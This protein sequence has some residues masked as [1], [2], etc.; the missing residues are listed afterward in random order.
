MDWTF[1]YL[2]KESAERYGAVIGKGWGFFFLEMRIIFASFLWKDAV[3]IYKVNLSLYFQDKSY[4]QIY[5]TPNDLKNWQN[6]A[7][8]PFS[9]DL[10]VYRCCAFLHTL[11]HVLFCP[12]YCHQ[13]SSLSLIW[14]PLYGKRFTLISWIGVYLP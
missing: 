1:K 6:L 7:G 8:S 4:E 3:Y 2:G 9:T 14:L 11:L 5:P 12:G 13:G 10:W